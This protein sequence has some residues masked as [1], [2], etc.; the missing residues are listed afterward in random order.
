[1][2]S[3]I[4]DNNFIYNIVCLAINIYFATVKIDIEKLVLLLIENMLM[5]VIINNPKW[6]IS[7]KNRNTNNLL[8][9]MLVLSCS[10][11]YILNIYL[12]YKYIMYEDVAWCLPLLNNSV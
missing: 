12:N 9:D 10:I 6:F 2:L 1:M 7:I 4:I 3:N 5:I 8:M 11:Y